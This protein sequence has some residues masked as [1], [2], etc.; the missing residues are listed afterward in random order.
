MA[1]PEYNHRTRKFKE[2]QNPRI[3]K[4]FDT[5]D[6]INPYFIYPFIATQSNKT[7]EFAKVRKVFYKSTASIP[8]KARHMGVTLSVIGR[9][10]MKW[11][12][13]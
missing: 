2:A 8:G 7:I 13:Y 4:V 3:A 1:D 5:P 11:I 10:P 6:E 12:E 9:A